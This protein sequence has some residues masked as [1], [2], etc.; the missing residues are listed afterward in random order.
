MCVNL[1]E[2][3]HQILYQSQSDPGFWSYKIS[4]FSEHLV[5][6]NFSEILVEKKGRKKIISAAYWKK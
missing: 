2:L 4:E 6:G 1:T 5:L 3:V